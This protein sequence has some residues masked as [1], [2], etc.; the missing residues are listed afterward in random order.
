MAKKEMGKDDFLRALTEG[1]NR[2][3]NAPNMLGY[4]PHAK[5]VAFHSSDRRGR[6]YIGGNRSGKSVGGIV[7]DCFWLTGKHPYIKTPPPPVRGRIVGVDFVNGIEK[8]LRPLLAQ[9]MPL[10]ELKGGSWDKAY[11]K[12][13]RTLYLENGSFVEF[14]SYDQDLD[15]FAGTSR[16]FIH[17]DEEC[18]ED[19][20]TECRARLIDTGGSWWMT[21]TPVEGMTW[22]YDNIYLPGKTGSDPNIG[23]VEIDM[24][25]NPHISSAEIDMFLAGLGKDEAKARKEGKFVQIGGLVFKSF[26]TDVHVVDDFVP[27]LD[28]EWYVSL[29]H[30]YNNPTAILWHAVSP[31]GKVVTFSESYEAEKTIDQHAATIHARNASFGRQPDIY[32]GDPAMAQRS[33]VTGISVFGEYAKYGI[34]FIP[35]TN[36][37]VSG[38]SRVNQY[39]HHGQ[40]D[41]PK[42]VITKG[43]R[44]LIWEMQRLRWKTW[45]NKR[46]AGNNN[47]YDVIHKKDDHACD[48][49]RY[50]FTVLPTL[51][52]S[53]FKANPMVVRPFPAMAGGATHMSEPK[54]WQFSSKFRHDEF[55]EGALDDSVGY[56]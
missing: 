40:D 33:A 1:L 39:L 47:K 15:K 11:N 26:D 9:W 5:Q 24:S 55:N 34:P 2:A 30:G 16:H 50:F 53:E 10:S 4:V 41:P 29:D 31:E 7:E 28:W 48:S 17:F 56:W 49:A 27:P 52:P 45:A 3:A 19:I 21:E 54:D 12:E 25:E 35:G 38:I 44:N 20:F 43:C 14:M 32:V 8:I 22:V 51:E 42:W 23:V 18:P 46:S 13:T 36:D 6:L 37:V